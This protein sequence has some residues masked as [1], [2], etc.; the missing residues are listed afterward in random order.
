MAVVLPTTTGCISAVW[1]KSTWS[2]PWTDNCVEVDTEWRKAS[3]SSTDITCVEVKQGAVVAVRDSLDPQGAVL[4]F[5]RDEWVAFVEGVK[6][7]EFD[8]PVH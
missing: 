8:L 4:E 5:T 1:R 2:G 3:G 7:G 6:L